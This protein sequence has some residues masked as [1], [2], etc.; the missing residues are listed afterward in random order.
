[1]RLFLCLSLFVLWLNVDVSISQTEA[2]GCQRP[3]PLSG[4][5]IKHTMKSQYSHNE[6]VE[7]M[8]QRYYTMEGERY[9][10]CIDGEW[11]GQM[12]CL[13]PC[14]VSND[15]LSQH[16]IAFKYSGINKMYSTHNDVIQF[17]C[18]TGRP[19]GSVRLRQRCDNGV[20]LLPSCQEH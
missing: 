20:L 18:T 7:Y 15:D 16:N 4:G 10:T 8:C 6:R 9:R 1:M 5:D 2:V 19:V 13:K 14:T 11:T 3:P 12:R 17:K